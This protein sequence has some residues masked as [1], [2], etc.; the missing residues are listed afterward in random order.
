MRAEAMRIALTSGPIRKQVASDM[1][2]ED[3]RRARAT[4]ER[5]PPYGSS[6]DWN[7]FSGGLTQTP[8]DRSLGWCRLAHRCDL[9][10]T[11]I[12]LTCRSLDLSNPGALC[13]KLVSKV[14]L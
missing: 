9:T 14:L 1:G 7:Q 8:F 13:G 5:H 10:L 3:G 6:Y 4:A 2:G 12:D 11:R